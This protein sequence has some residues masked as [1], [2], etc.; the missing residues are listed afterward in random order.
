MTRPLPKRLERLETRALPLIIEI[1][2]VSATDRSVTKRMTVN[3]G[4]ASGPST[5]RGSRA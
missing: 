2:F 5:R 1:E 4:V 3:C